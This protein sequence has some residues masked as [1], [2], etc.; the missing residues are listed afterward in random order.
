M[1][2]A[3]NTL[4]G[5]T[6]LSVLSVP[7]PPSERVSFANDSLARKFPSDPCPPAAVQSV[8][9]GTLKFGL[10]SNSIELEFGDDGVALA[11]AVASRRDSTSLISR[12]GG[13]GGILT[14]SREPVFFARTQSPAFFLRG[15]RKLPHFPVVGSRA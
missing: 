3:R 1:I 10:S 6:G 12:V 15:R 11:G 13:L 5:S 8:I 4:S 14:N 2:A 9:P 7:L